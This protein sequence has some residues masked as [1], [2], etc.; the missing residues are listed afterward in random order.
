VVWKVAIVVFADF[1]RGDT[2]QRE[3]LTVVDLDQ[4]RAIQASTRDQQKSDVAA[5]RDIDRGR[6]RRNCRR[7]PPA[8]VMFNRQP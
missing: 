3:K 4:A 8:G 2:L 1:S 7:S 5:I 6:W